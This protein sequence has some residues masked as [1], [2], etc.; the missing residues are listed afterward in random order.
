MTFF[1]FCLISINIDVNKNKGMNSFYLFFLIE[2]K[3]EI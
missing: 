3:N 2:G 1:F